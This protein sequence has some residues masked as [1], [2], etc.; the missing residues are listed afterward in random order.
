MNKYMGN[1]FTLVLLI[2]SFLLNACGAGTPRG[3][4]T[5]D[6][7]IGV[8][9]A[10]AAVGAAAADAEIAVAD[11]EITAADAEI[12]AADAGVTESAR[13]GKDTSGGDADTGTGFTRSDGVAADAKPAAVTTNA[14]AVS[15]GAGAGAE[16]PASAE[17]AGGTL[18]DNSAYEFT[19][20]ELDALS[21]KKIGW[22]IKLDGHNQPQISKSTRESFVK[23]NT[24]YAG[25][26]DDPVLYLT[27]DLGYEN[28]NTDKILD[29]LQA[30]GVK[31]TFFITGHY[32][33][34]QPDIVKRIISDG[35]IAA[36]HSQNHKCLPDI[37]DDGVI[38]EILGFESNFREVTGAELSKFLRPPSGEYSERSLALTASLGYKTILWSFAYVD[39]DEKK[40]V[41]EEYAYNKITGNFHNGA[42]I[43]L[44]TVRSE[45]ASVL[46]KVIEKAR[47]EGYSFSTVD[48]IGKI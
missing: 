2:F 32:L 40:P 37:S 43:L 27:F 34:S 13:V 33:A 47:G 41:T 38:S 44:H 39:Y 16:A 29:T 4:M 35:H 17:N 36:N 48:G 8:A 10:G 26:P 25:N 24:V 23:F 19:A 22:G 5:Y 1:A 46:E 7:K 30:A 11:A 15:D 14:A 6:M 9:A 18:N 42:V 28:G 3:Q 31:A 12:A 45:N 20:A 21:K